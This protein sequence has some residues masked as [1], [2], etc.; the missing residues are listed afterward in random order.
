MSE[1]AGGEFGTVREL[2]RM[3]KKWPDTGP[4]GEE[5]EVWIET[6]KGLSSQATHGVRLG[7][8]DLLIESN[9]FDGEEQHA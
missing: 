5:T 3:L 7:V 4:N 9:S 6:G 2:K 1:M 8:A